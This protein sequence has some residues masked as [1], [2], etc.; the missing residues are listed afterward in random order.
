MIET[1]F[2]GRNKIFC[3]PKNW[4]ELPRMLLVATTWLYNKIKEMRCL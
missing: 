3:G 1:N 4:R 2:S